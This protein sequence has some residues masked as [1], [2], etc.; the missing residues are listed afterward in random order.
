M[1]G[2]R[3]G[4]E[5]LAGSRG[6]KSSWVLARPSRQANTDQAQ[7]SQGRF[8]SQTHMGHVGH[9]CFSFMSVFQ[10]PGL[11]PGLSLWRQLWVAADA[12]LCGYM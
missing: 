5:V 8:A 10:T 6:C 12:A 3:K 7:S 4:P 1:G 11:A 2:L 9:V